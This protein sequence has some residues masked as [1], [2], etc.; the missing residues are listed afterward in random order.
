MGNESIYFARYMEEE[1]TCS[2]VSIGKGKGILLT[3]VVTTSFTR[4]LIHLNV[5]K[6]IMNSFR[7]CQLLVASTEH[8]GR[9]AVEELNGIYSETFVSGMAGLHRLGRYY[10]QPDTD[11]HTGDCRLCSI[12]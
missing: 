1:P 7:K 2:I 9:P 11:S 10:I 12:I 3:G 5:T 8:S 4:K 6:D